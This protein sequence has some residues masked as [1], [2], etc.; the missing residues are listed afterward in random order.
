MIF[1]APWIVVKMLDAVPLPQGEMR[2]EM[3]ESC[4]SAGVR[5]RDLMLWRTGGTP[6][7]WGRDGIFPRA[8]WV[9]LTDGL[10]ERLERDELLAVLGHEL[11]HVRN[12]HMFWL[13]ASLIAISLGLGACLDPFFALLQNAIYDSGGDFHTMSRR[14]EWL[15]V[16]AAGSV[17]IGTL[18]GFGWVSRR[19]ER[20]ADAFAAVHLSRI[21]PVAAVPL[22]L[23]EAVEAMRSALGSVAVFNGVDPARRSW[24]HGSISS[25]QQQ[26]AL[27]TGRPTNEL[28]VDAVVNWI[29]VASVVLIIAGIVFFV[30]NMSSGMEV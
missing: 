17:L 18:V 21:A 1:I 23:P 30:L 26:L 15:N 16:G 7:E 2:R 14:M 9:L 20:Q 24:R 4:R 28:P 6:G 8:R 11:A 3:E 27:I 22:V 5:V 10:M 29:K 13:A 19:F 25:R 12:R